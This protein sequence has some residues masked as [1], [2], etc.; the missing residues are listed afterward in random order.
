MEFKVE[1]LTEYSVFMDKPTVEN[2]YKLVT[3]IAERDDLNLRSARAYGE[4]KRVYP[5][6]ISKEIKSMIK[7]MGI[8]H[9]FSD[10]NG[11]SVHLLFKE[12]NAKKFADKL[13]EIM[14]ILDNKKLPATISDITP[15]HWGTFGAVVS[16]SRKIEGLKFAEQYIDDLGNLIVRMKDICIDRLYETFMNN[17][18]TLR[19]EDLTSYMFHVNL[20]KDGYVIEAKYNKSDKQ[21][22]S[23]IAVEGVPLPI[24]YVAETDTMFLG[25]D[26]IG[27]IKQVLQTLK[28]N[29]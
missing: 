12:M 27:S 13:Y 26:N 19:E 16:F 23:T 17:N 15:K 28:R 8:K 6:G 20:G 1:E 14:T 11:G 5:K 24:D 29:E 10:V 18:K 21:K 7:A 25:D 22:Y 9:Y 4:V 3:E 2:G